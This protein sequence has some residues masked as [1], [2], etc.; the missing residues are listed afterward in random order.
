MLWYSAFVYLTEG[1][2]QMETNTSETRRYDIAL[3][4]NEFKKIADSLPEM[5]LAEEIRCGDGKVVKGAETIFSSQNSDEV[6]NGLLGFA[7]RAVDEKKHLALIIRNFF[8]VGG[9]VGT[10]GELIFL[11]TEKILAGDF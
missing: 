11:N 1:F 6:K 10:R 7:R 4:S 2:F 9:G 3:M 8:P 5:A